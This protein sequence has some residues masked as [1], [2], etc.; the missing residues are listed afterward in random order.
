MTTTRTSSFSTAWLAHET[1]A[2]YPQPESFEPECE[3]FDPDLPVFEVWLDGS[4]FAATQCPAR[5]FD[6]LRAMTCAAAA[7]RYGHRWVELKVV[8]D[9]RA[10]PR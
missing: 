3:P 1:G 10:T 9:R 8:G 7:R 2:T 4:R 5:A 6:T